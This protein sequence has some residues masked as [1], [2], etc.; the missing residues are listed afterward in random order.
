M[1]GLPGYL[2]LDCRWDVGPLTIRSK[3]AG[4]SEG[5]WTFE[6]SRLA[7]LTAH[8]I[9][10]SDSV[11]DRHGEHGAG[12]QARIGEALPSAQLWGAFCSEGVTETTKYFQYCY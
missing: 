9:N 8:T 4:R 3:C 10:W 2:E 5:V 12:S 1:V 11:P 6:T 7:L